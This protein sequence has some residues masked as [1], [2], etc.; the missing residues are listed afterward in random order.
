MT[1]EHSDLILVANIINE[2]GFEIFENLIKLKFKGNNCLDR[3]TGDAFS[4]G[5][6]KGTVFAYAEMLNEI[7][8]LRKQVKNLR[9][10]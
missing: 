1:I 9:R 2:P 8:N 3:I 6:Q 5:V 7:S 10:D 4:D